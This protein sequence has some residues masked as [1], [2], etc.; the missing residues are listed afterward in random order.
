MSAGTYL[1]RKSANLCTHPSCELQPVLGR[2]RCAAHLEKERLKGI[3]RRRQ[4]PTLSQ[5]ASASSRSRRVAAGICTNCSEKATPGKKQCEKH[6]QIARDRSTR[7]NYKLSA[8]ELAQIRREKFCGLCG[9][10]FQGTRHEPLAPV[11]DHHHGTGQRRGVIHQK[12]NV[13]LGMF[14]EN[15]DLMAAAISYLQ[16]YKM[17][18][19]A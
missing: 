5:R 2:T 15:I 6:R 12:C 11:I 3:E 17:K 19:V 8:S 1:R 13:A 16:Y 10:P 4:D 7:S 18:R 14:E 9:K